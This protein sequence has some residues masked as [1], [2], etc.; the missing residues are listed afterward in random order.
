MQCSG[1]EV[2]DA[3]LL[4]ELGEILDRELVQERRQGG[5][6]GCLDAR[7][8]G[9]CERDF[10][11][12]VRPAEAVLAPLLERPV[13]T[14]S[15][16]DGRSERVRVDSECLTGHVFGSQRCDCRE[17]L[18][19]ALARIAKEG[20]G[21][22]LYL[23]QEGRGIGLMNKLR[24]YALQDQ[25]LDTVEAN[26]KLGFKPDQREYGIGVQILLDLGV[27][28]ARIL[29]NNPHK[30]VSLYPGLEVVE[31]VPIEVEARATNRGY[32]ATKRTKLGHL[33]S[34]VSDQE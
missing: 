23:R 11:V 28:K 31:R 13:R 27:R 25:G 18:E 32:L 17:Q 26:E 12:L 3:A 1:A 21:V 9:Q 30:L 10:E 7:L 20:R 6:E 22:F 14:A 34:V 5:D 19:A 33:L 15:E 4:Q 24:A 2:F 8:G 16:L 29:T